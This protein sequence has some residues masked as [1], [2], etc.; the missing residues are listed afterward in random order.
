MVIVTLKYNITS[1][2]INS[3]LYFFILTYEFNFG[4]YSLFPFQAPFV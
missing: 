1:Q 4:F 2:K 3:E